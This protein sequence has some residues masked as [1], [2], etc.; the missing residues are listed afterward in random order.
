MISF[1]KLSIFAEIYV[2]F[3]KSYRTFEML[4]II[5]EIDYLKIQN[6]FITKPLQVIF[7]KVS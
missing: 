7:V 4:I 1:Q 5:C 2:T 6:S 3:Q